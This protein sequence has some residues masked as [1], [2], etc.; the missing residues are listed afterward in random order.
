MIL[1]FDAFWVSIGSNWNLGAADAADGTEYRFFVNSVDAIEG[2]SVEAGVKMF[3]DGTDDGNIFEINGAYVFAID[4]ATTLTAAG[5][6]AN[7]SEGMLVAEAADYTF[8]AADVYLDQLYGAGFMV[9]YMVDDMT[10]LNVGAEFSG[11]DD[12]AFRVMAGGVGLAYG[13]LGV[14]VD[15]AYAMTRSY[16]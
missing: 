9:D 4:D 3:D 10:A 11:D 15:M 1:D 14:D 2:L 8:L 5:S 7:A 12:E 13:D 6:F 16:L